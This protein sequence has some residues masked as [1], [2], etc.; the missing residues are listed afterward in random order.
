MLQNL[1]EISG[2]AFLQASRPQ[3]FDPKA[4]KKLIALTTTING[5]PQCQLSDSVA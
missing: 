5:L 1:S 2:T 3:L 4:L